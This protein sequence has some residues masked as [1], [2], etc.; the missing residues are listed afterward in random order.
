MKPTSIV[1]LVVVT[2][3]GVGSAVWLSAGEERNKPWPKPTPPPEASQ[4]FEP[5]PEPA[6]TV[7]EIDR[8]IADHDDVIE[9]E[10]ES[11]FDSP[12][13]E[14][15]EAAFVFLLPE[16]LQLSPQRVTAMVERQQP[17][18]ARDTLRTELTRLW[19]ATDAGEAIAWIK[20][21]NDHE[22]RASARTA[23]EWITPHDPQSALR[24]AHELGLRG[25]VSAARD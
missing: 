10:L 6:Q 5:S 19:I 7:E 17:G 13:P 22:R 1:T 9:R 21:L 23:V 4:E 20:S 12:D 25:R 3:L 18:R 11:S 8:E 14:R 24:V 2:L 16:L 15:R